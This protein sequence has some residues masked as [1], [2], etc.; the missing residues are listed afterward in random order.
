MKQE[1]KKEKLKLQDNYQLS[2]RNLSS[3]TTCSLNSKELSEE[4]ILGSKTIY[5]PTSLNQ[6]KFKETENNSMKKQNE[7]I[8]EF[9]SSPKK[10][11]FST[12]LSQEINYSSPLCNY[13]VETGNYFREKNP[14][15][16]EYKESKNYLEKEIFFSAN[17]K[18]TSNFD[19]YEKQDKKI[20]NQKKISKNLFLNDFTNNLETSQ[21]T[22]MVIDV[23][24][25][26]NY[27][28]PFYYIGYYNIDIDKLIP[29]F[30]IQQPFY[31]NTQINK[32]KNNNQKYKS[33]QRKNA[34]IRN[35]DW[36]CKNCRNLNFAFRLICNRCKKDKKDV[37]DL[38]I[39]KEM[40]SNQKL[41]N[42]KNYQKFKKNENKKNKNLE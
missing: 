36:V 3:K 8:S 26:S 38:D 33:K 14:K 15:K 37:E 5:F 34:P 25:M 6:V 35:D 7:T 2:E 16:N 19:S 13:F 17:K 22:N 12:S 41:L 9:K 1:A 23:N 27:S 10:I 4:K 20:Q 31:S 18:T 11:K 21:I 29:N 40:E 42:N 28:F 32:Q 39:K 30:L 24:N